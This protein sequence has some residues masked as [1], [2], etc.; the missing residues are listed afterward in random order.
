MNFLHL[1]FFLL[2]ASDAFGQAMSAAKDMASANSVVDF[3]EDELDNAADDDEDDL[4]GLA[5]RNAELYLPSSEVRDRLTYGF[6]FG[7]GR[8]APYSIYQMTGDY[9]LDGSRVLS[10]GVGF[11]KTSSECATSDR[12]YSVTYRAT[13][14]TG[15]TRVFLTDVV[16]VYA[17]GGLFWAGL[18]GTVTSSGPT[19][20]EDHKF[21]ANTFGPVAVLGFQSIWESGRAL[22]YR[23]I[24]VAKNILKRRINLDDS[25]ASDALALH[26]DMAETFG[27]I[28][29][30]F[31]VYF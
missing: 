12:V 22:D 23:V 8:L 29:L 10:L 25:S 4:D 16:P 20:M 28:N 15:L 9:F 2:L 19:S 3:P 17:G 11:G 31:S 27:L 18:T 21:S 30:A 26:L 7:V 24:G 5:R 6:G 1:A 13:A 14:I